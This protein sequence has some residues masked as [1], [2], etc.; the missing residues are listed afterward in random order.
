M[1]NGQLPRKPLSNLGPHH[2]NHRNR[3]QE[4]YRAATLLISAISL[5]GALL[6]FGKIILDILDQG[7]TEVR[8]G[9]PL[10]AIIIAVA[11][12]LGW[13][14]ALLGTRR[15]NNLFLPILLD[16]YAWA[17][18]LGICF[19]YLRAIA[20][21]FQ[22][23]FTVE[24]YIA[25]WGLLFVCLI[26]LSGLELAPEGRKMH[27]FSIPIFVVCLIHLLGMIAHYV[28][29]G[30]RTNLAVDYA[31]AD[32]FLFLGMLGVG[33][34]LLA[35][36]PILNPLRNWLARLFGSTDQTWDRR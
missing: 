14:V 7:W 35:N 17:I 25:V 30:A 6:G 32:L 29:V 27:R 18:T 2:G 22:E 16:I 3:R 4:F 20:R 19:L 33:A 1:L 28:F 13:V 21:L 36:V 15:A 12:A 9:I 31:A 5:G 10:Q 8:A 11:Y 23:V 34:L 26:A 24:K